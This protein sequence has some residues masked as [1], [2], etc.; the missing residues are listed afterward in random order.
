MLEELR[1]ENLGVIDSI[2][3][4]LPPGSIAV[5]GE[6]G[7][8]KTMVL[9][10]IQLL[11][12]ARAEPD[13]VRRGT[14][15]A[16]IEG[17]FVDADGDEIVAKRVIPAS[18]RSRA[19]L[20]GSLAT[21]TE[22]QERIA[23]MVDLHGQHSQQSLLRPSTQRDALDAFAGVDTEPLRSIRSKISQID[24][25]LGELGGDETERARRVDLL[26]Y[27]LDELVAAN[28]SD[29]DEDT[30]LLAEESLLA[31]AFEH[32]LSAARAGELVGA[33]GPAAEALVQAAGLLDGAGPFADALGRLIALQEDLAGLSGELRDIGEGI[34]DDPEAREHVRQR[35]SL[36]VELRRKYGPTLSDVIAYTSDLQQQLDE[37]E[38]HEVRVTQLADQRDVAIRERDAL[39]TTIL[40]QRARASEPLARAVEAELAKLSMANATVEVRVQGSA[41]DDVAIMLAP[42]PGLPLVPVGKGASGGELSRTMLALRLV[43][44][45]GPP[46]QVFDEVDAGIGGGT[47]RA[48]GRALA[49]LGTSGQVFVVTHLAQVASYAGSHIVID[50]S[51]IEGTTKSQAR[52]L[53]KDER[54]IEVSRMLS[55]SPESSVAHVHAQEL[56]ATTSATWE[57]A[58]AR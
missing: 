5:T 10:A 46:I 49:S 35:L 56:L 52:V 13:M 51:S 42:N 38:S 25:E 32:Q 27:Q 15:Q 43:L 12:G 7:A 47:A 37:L 55:G 31:N 2:S 30:A 50:K 9:S 24:A 44:A 18:G 1:I 22:L 16:T 53:S 48:V 34:T 4:V 45:G 40:E 57:T 28:L 36:L 41:G 11:M 8:G 26:R 17:R 19:Y 33:D 14:D 54:I 29:P 20:D 23:P 3:L 39:A 21:A 6:T 58:G